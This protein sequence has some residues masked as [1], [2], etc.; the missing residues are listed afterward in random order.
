MKIF[1]KNPKFLEKVKENG[2]YFV[3]IQNFEKKGKKDILH[4]IKILKEDGDDEDILQKSKI[5]EKRIRNVKIFCKNP[6][7]YQNRG[8]EN[9]VFCKN[10]KF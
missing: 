8:R 4:K 1:R 9:K 3:K 7:F 5:L 6:K 10:A 2:R